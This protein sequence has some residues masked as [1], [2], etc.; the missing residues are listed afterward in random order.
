[1][2]L[3]VTLVLCVLAGL[4][5][6]ED[7]KYFYI[8]EWPEYFSDVWPP[9]SA[10]LDRDTPYSHNFRSSITGI[11][12]PIDPDIGYFNTWQ[13]S[14][15]KLAMA[16]LLVDEHRTMDPEKATSF[17]VPFDIGVHSFLDH[18]TGKV[19]VASPHGWRAIEFF[20]QTASQHVFNK[21]NFH[22]HFILVSSSYSPNI[23]CILMFLS[24]SLLLR[25]RSVASDR[26]CSCV[27]T[28]RTAR[29]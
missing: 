16:R 11:G 2:L 20:K 26:R 27:N 29:C 28:A 5:V 22:D 3:Q 25:T 4:C 18:R 13:F 1:M 24:S 6:G 10:V 19:R 21:N 7:K 14:L 15:Y 23:F 8:Y 9:A 17:I 12:N